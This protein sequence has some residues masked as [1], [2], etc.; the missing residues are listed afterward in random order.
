M[1][2]LAA[3]YSSGFQSVR[4]FLWLMSGTGGARQE[5]SSATVVRKVPALAYREPDASGGS[6]IAS[7]AGANPVT[8]RR[9]SHAGRPLV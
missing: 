5:C 2:R 1:E 9:F 4:A 3:T 8:G 7:A 6:P